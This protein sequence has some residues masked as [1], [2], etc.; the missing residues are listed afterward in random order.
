MTEQ[1]IKDKILELSPWYHE[2]YLGKG[3]ITGPL[4]ASAMKEE[5]A[6]TR[7]VRAGIDYTGKMVL[8]LGAADGMWAFEA[9]DLGAK[10]IVAADMGQSSYIP[11]LLFAKQIRQSKV[12]PYFGVIVQDLYNRLDC[13]F[14]YHSNGELFDVVQ[15][16]GLLY[17][18]R[19]PLLV[20]SE[21]R[22]CIKEGG[23]L[24]LETAV[25]LDDSK[26]SLALLNYPEGRIYNDESTWWA[27]NKS[28]LLAMC[29][30]S[31]FEPDED[32]VSIF[33]Q[34]G[35]ASIGRI[36][37]RAKAVGIGSVSQHMATELGWKFPG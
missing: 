15:N 1:E 2:I 12:I 17:H 18:V 30:M 33:V 13:F 10:T 37:L 35:T 34:P 28:C 4:M 24:L 8:D 22:R 26:E 19:D 16:L 9:E 21:S 36:C 11:R 27:P 3:F 31:L 6:S 29:K 5:W 25:Y 23:D 20:L 7:R 14:T 32:S